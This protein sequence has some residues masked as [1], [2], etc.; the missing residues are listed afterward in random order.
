MISA[1]IRVEQREV[2]STEDQLEVCPNGHSRGE[3]SMVHKEIG[4]DGEE[5]AVWQKRVFGKRPSTGN[6]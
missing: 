4:E 3:V 5:V 1:T 2:S 6:G